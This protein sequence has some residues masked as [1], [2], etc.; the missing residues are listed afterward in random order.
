MRVLEGLC[1]YRQKLA[2][3]Y[4]VYPLNAGAK[5]FEKQEN[6]VEHYKGQQ[7]ICHFCSV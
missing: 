3:A 2:G 6:Q 7:R 4:F 1:S 5:N